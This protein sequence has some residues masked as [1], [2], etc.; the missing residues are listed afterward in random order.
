MRR[1]KGEDKLVFAVTSEDWEKAK[2]TWMVLRHKRSSVDRTNLEDFHAEMWIQVQKDPK[3]LVGQPVLIIAHENHTY[4]TGHPYPA[5]ILKV[6][7]SGGLP[8]IRVLYHPIAEEA[9]DGE[10]I[11]EISL[12]QV[13]PLIDQ[14]GVT[15]EEKTELKEGLIFATVLDKIN[16]T[17]NVQR[18]TFQQRLSEY[19]RAIGNYQ[20]EVMK[21]D[22][23]IKKT[24]D[25]L[26]SAEDKSLDI[27]GLKALITEIATHRKVEWAFLS[28]AG[29]IV[30]QT[31]MLYAT[32]PR[33]NTENLKKE[34]GRFAF[35]FNPIDHNIR[36]MNL[37]YDYNG[38]RHPNLN[39]DGICKGGNSTEMDDLLKTGRFYELVD[40]M[41]LFFS[42]FP[43]DSGSP[44]VPHRTWLA[45]KLPSHIVNPYN[46]R[47]KMF[48]VK[49]STIEIKKRKKKGEATIAEPV[50]EPKIEL[51][52]DGNP[53]AAVFV[54]DESLDPATEIGTQRGDGRCGCACDC[55]TCN[56]L[57][58]RC[59]KCKC[60]RTECTECGCSCETCNCLDESCDNCGCNNADS[61]S[62]NC[63]VCDCD[64][65]SCGCENE[66][67]CGDCECDNS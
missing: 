56:C 60:G 45:G 10:R 2:E 50:A 35:L 5:T 27:D 46:N 23:L 26:K 8:R 33:N 12:L 6:I 42:L 31:K 17:R 7:T 43:H 24:T 47:T 61:D 20:R 13:L 28:T 16:V 64:C 63:S 54:A 44:Y 9:W 59:A 65:S 21:Y 4:H 49:S 41:V 1:R 29:D 18:T 48:E 32:G 62:N 66:G 51:D 30:V 14:P 58:T 40:L 39:S 53:V 3:K 34:V 67:G 37:D 52:S 38:H 22:G 36:A 15:A 25:Q 57:N 11:Q 55:D 19:E